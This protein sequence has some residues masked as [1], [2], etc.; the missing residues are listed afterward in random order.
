MCV[1]YF[2]LYYFILICIIAVGSELFDDLM[3]SES[4]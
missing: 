3:S 2:Y 1:C 4:K